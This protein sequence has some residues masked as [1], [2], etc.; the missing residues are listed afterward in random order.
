MA[1]AIKLTN[2][3]TLQDLRNS[4][5]RFGHRTEEALNSFEAELK[6]TLEFMQSR[7]RACQQRVEQK[8]W[9]VEKARDSLQ[10]CRGQEDDDYTPDCSAE[11]NE[12]RQAIHEF[13]ST[14]KNFE[15]AK[16]LQ[17][18]VEN[19]ISEFHKHIRRLRELATANVDKANAYLEN[20]IVTVEKYRAVQPEI[21]KFIAT[22]S[23]M[24]TLVQCNVVTTAQSLATNTLNGLAANEQSLDSDQW[25]GTWTNNFDL[26]NLPSPEDIEGASDFRKVKFDEMKDGLSKLQEM[27]PIIEQGVGNSKDYWANI[28]NEKGLDYPNGYQRVYEA[29]YGNEPIRV[30]KN[31][32]NYEITNGRHRIWSAKKLGIKTLPLMLV[33]RK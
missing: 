20:K 14:K 10:Y 24:A 19:A 32:N 22:D 5:R 21:A 13:E 11:E 33:E 29:F 26:S 18:K 16:I 6:R 7:V 8:K 12:L 30:I 28:D 15:V 3:D 2:I 1:G 23:D 4:F 9:E 17:T 27:K 25:V 31:G